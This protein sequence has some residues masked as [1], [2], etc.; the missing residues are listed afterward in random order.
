MATHSS[1]LAWR[2]PGTGKPGGLP[3]RGS[4]RV[5]HDWSNLAAAAAASGDGIKFYRLRN[6]CNKTIPTLHFWSQM[7]AQVITCASGQLAIN[8]TTHSLDFINLL[9]WLKELKETFYGIDVWYR[10]WEKD[11][12]HSCSLPTCYSSQISRC[13]ANWKLSKH[14]PLGILW[15]LYCIRSYQ[16]RS[17]AQLCPTLGDPM[18]PSTPGLPVH[19]KLRE[20]TQTPVHQVSDAMQSSH[21]LSSPS[22]PV[23]NPSQHQ[24]LFQWVSSSQEVAKVLEFRLQ[25]HTLQ[26]NPRAYLLQNGLVGSLY[27]SRDSQESFP[28]PQ[29]KCINSS[30]LNLLHSPI[31]SIHDHRKNH[32]LD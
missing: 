18:N 11:K 10:I 29:F 26:R 31:T 5:G 6:Q 3:S 16:I 8:K 28:T 2:I 22:P 1:V 14:C 12:E 23:H 15:R 32:S 30:M 25:H 21:P 27:S 9:E 20:F 24:S 4:H 13:S 17:V 7:Q 19:H